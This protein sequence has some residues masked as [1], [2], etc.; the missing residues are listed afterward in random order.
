MQKPK[1]IQIP[2]SGESM[3]PL[4]DGN[5]TLF[6]D[7]PPEPIM[8]SKKDV[9]SLFIFKDHSEWL[10]HRYL[11]VFN[12]THL[13]KGDYAISFESIPMPHVMG[14]VRGFNV[15]GQKYREIH[16]TGLDVFIAWVQRGSIVY[17]SKMKKFFRYCALLLVL[18]RKRFL[19]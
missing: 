15:Q 1:C 19:N 17:R 3:W 5:E 18:I 10:C 8:L 4:F 7:I 11:G 14:R 16:T 2:F 6:V 12:N 13:F 9:G